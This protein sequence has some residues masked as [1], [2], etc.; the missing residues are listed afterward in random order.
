MIDRKQTIVNILQEKEGE[1]IRR[2]WNKYCNEEN[3]DD[4]IYDNDEYELSQM[5]SG[6]SAVSDAL[7][8]ACYGEYKF[9]DAYVIFNGYG[10]LV[11]FGESEL[12][13]HIDYDTLSDYLMDNGDEEDYFDE[14]DLQTLKD[15]FID[16]YEEKNRKTFVEDENFDCIGY[17]FITT[18]WDEI[19]EELNEQE[20]DEESN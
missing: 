18:D 6:S 5:F 9:T 11:S 14:D 16:Y 7:R 1:A 17:D 12:N 19:I 2:I 3:P 4:Y 20:D 15:N 13:E 8:T 10:N